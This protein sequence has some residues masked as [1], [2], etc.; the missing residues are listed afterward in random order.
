MKVYIVFDNNNLPV[1]VYSSQKGAEQRISEVDFD[2]WYFQGYTVIEDITEMKPITEVAK[3]EFDPLDLDD[4]MP[5]GKYKGY[6]LSEVIEVDPSYLEW[7]CNNLN[8]KVTEDVK[9]YIKYVK[10]GKN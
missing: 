9:E 2:D 6:T 3:K 5:F 8:V 10:G 4:K 7:C 1:D